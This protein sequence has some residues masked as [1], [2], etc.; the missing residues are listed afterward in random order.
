MSIEVNKLGEF[1]LAE[2]KGLDIT[3]PIAPETWEQVNQAFLD[4]GVLVFRDQPLTPVLMVQFAGHF[5][6]LQPHITKKYWHPEFNQLIIM[7]NL[8]ENGEINPADDSRGDAWHTD[9]CYLEA[10]AKATML[11][12]QQIPD[13][14]GDTE[15]ANMTKAFEEMPAK[16]KDRI[17]H[18]MATFRNG[19]IE[20]RGA[21]RL[22]DEDKARK[23][24]PHPAIRTHPETGR[25]SVFVNPA[26]AV[27]IKGM[28]EDEAWDLLNEVFA[29]C[30]QDRFQD[31]HHWRMNDTV[32]WDN[33]CCWHRATADNPLQQPRI[34][35]RTTVRG[36]PTH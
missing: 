9:M 33:R 26:H 36:T 29:W 12:T 20:A 23:P 17:E 24:I 35:L 11:H 18:K 16:L 15:F 21:E 31:R 7:T 3:K 2:V 6:E 19:G 1:I 5:G 32:V 30:I 28:E 14:G 13:M 22:T 25:K 34:F 4:H 8:D 10:P 27:S